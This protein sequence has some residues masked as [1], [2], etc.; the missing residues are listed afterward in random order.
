[1]RPGGTIVRNLSLTKFR[2]ESR[3]RGRQSWEAEMQA[4][5]EVKVTLLLGGGH[6]ETVTMSP[7]DPMLRALLTTIQ[8]KSRGVAEH[9]PYHIRIDGGRRSLV[10]SGID[11]VGVQ[12]DPPLAIQVAGPVSGAAETPVQ[13]SR[14][15]IAENFL[16]PEQHRALLALV[17][18]EEARF[19]D[20]SVSTNDPD[21]RRSK[22]LHEAPEVHELFRTRMRELAPRLMAELGIPPF[23]LG[24][25]EVQVTAHNDGNYFKLHN[26]SGSPDTATRGLTY[27]YYFFNEPKAFTGGE[28]RLYDSIVKDG[29]YQCGPQ[30][31]D[32]DPKNNSVIFFAPYVHHEVLKV[33]VPSKAFHDGRFTVNGWLRRAA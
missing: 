8:D 15:V 33:S 16:P 7:Q 19:V 9:R 26:D 25:V 11:L 4:P 29:Y 1:M 21:Y 32:V 12:T 24:D 23:H 22:V 2:E 14:Y 6:R 17:A 13:K 27:V 30:A 18:R 31:A 5:A 10:F 28:L 20:T 3:G